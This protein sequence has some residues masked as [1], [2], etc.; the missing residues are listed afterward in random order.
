MGLSFFTQCS[1]ALNRSQPLKENSSVMDGSPRRRSSLLKTMKR[2]SK[3]AR[4]KSDRSNVKRDKSKEEP[5]QAPHSI[6]QMRAMKLI[7]DAFRVSSISFGFY[8]MRGCRAQMQD[9]VLT[10]LN[11]MD[12]E[13]ESL[14]AV[15]DGHGGVESARFARANFTT[16]FKKELRE[17]YACKSSDPYSVQTNLRSRRAVDLTA[18]SREG[19]SGG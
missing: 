17:G 10:K 16:I 9:A 11:F 4:S 14:F 6:R 1:T 5:I 13:D 8:S 2:L 7:K 15:F 3:T 18:S 12:S 19:K